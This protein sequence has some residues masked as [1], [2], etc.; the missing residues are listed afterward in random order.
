MPVPPLIPDTYAP[1]SNGFDPYDICFV[2]AGEYAEDTNG[3][4]TYEEE[5]AG[6]YE[7]AYA[8][9]L[10]YVATAGAYE[11][12]YAT[13]LPYDPMAGDD[14]YFVT[15]GA[16][17]STFDAYPVTAG[18]MPYCRG[19]ATCFTTGDEMYAVETAGADEYFVTVG[20]EYAKLFVPRYADER[21]G[22]VPYVATPGDETYFVTAG[23]IF[24]TP[25]DE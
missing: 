13:L 7:P 23:E 3:L 24:E 5:T 4:E 10:P 25:N 9:L 15:A 6:A 8:T 12:A 2:T 1:P 17:T 21:D 18:L 14:T 22:L 19:D 11:S 16:T 20:L